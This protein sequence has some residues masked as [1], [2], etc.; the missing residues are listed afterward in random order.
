[1]TSNITWQFWIQL[2]LYQHEHRIYK[3]ILKDHTSVKHQNLNMHSTYFV[4][5]NFMLN[6]KFTLIQ[7][8]N[9]D[10]NLEQNDSCNKNCCKY[11]TT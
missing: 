9:I 5:F 7:I 11:I 2:F 1:M 6:D 10:T 3:D 4:I 8:S